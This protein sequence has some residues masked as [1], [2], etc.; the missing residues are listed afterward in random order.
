M[1]ERVNEELRRRI[2][3]A[4]IFPNRAS[5]LRLISALAVEQD[6]EWQTDCRYIDMGTAKSEEDVRKAS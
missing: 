5:Y 6:E 3:V 1:L 2:R 4:R